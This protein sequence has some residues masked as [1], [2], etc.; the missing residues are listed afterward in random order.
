MLMILNMVIQVIKESDLKWDD[1][2]EITL[3]F[4]K[5]VAKVDRAQFISGCLDDPGITKILKFLE[6]ISNEPNNTGC[7]KVDYPTNQSCIDFNTGH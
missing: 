1:R 2:V 3:A 5:M 6:V 7:Y 4:A